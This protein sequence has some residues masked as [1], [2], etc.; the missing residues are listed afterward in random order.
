MREVMRSIRQTF[1]GP[2]VLQNTN[3][4]AQFYY[5]HVSPRCEEARSISI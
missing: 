3:G 5:E 1:W 4:I 2:S